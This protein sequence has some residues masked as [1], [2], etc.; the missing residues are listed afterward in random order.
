MS[1]LDELVLDGLHVKNLDFLDLLPD[2]LRIE[3]C[4]VHVYGSVDVQKWKR[5]IERDICEISVGDHDW[6]YID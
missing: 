2:K 3:I 1:I 6:N 4:G 5:F